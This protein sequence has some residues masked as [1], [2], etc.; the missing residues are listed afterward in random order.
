MAILWIVGVCGLLIL[1]TFAAIRLSR[2]HA[3][4][5]SQ[6]SMEPTLYR[7]DRFFVNQDYYNHHA[8]ADGD[9]VALRHGDALVVKRISAI[10]GET[11][12][13]R[14]GRLIRNGVPLTEP[15]AA[16]DKDNSLDVETFSSRRVPTG[17]I[18]V[19]GDAR[20][21]SLDSRSAEYGPVHTEDVVGRVLY[22]YWSS[23]ANQRG[24]RF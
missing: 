24:R 16:Y 14:D 3:Y 13:G 21:R 8:L 19:T 18:F 17:E 7:G 2:F 6:G 20:D 15:Y 1:G 9:L 4:V 5:V 11:I 23:H 22:V 12:E 10:A